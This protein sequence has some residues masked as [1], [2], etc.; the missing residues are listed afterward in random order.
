MVDTPGVGEREEVTKKLVDYMQEAIAF[1]YVIN[2]ANAGGV[3]RD[4]VKV[5]Q[6]YCP[7]LNCGFWGYSN[8]PFS[9][10]MKVN[11][12]QIE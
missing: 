6:I 8:N 9:L 12:Y 1:I 11:F 7:A 4:R 3:Q 2:L 10:Q 5:L